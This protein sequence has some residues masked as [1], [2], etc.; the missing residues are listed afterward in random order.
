MEDYDALD[1]KK[2]IYIQFWKF[3]TNNKYKQCIVL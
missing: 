3:L 2:K 1:Y